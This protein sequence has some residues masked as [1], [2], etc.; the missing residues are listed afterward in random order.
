MK[1]QK[2]R[3]ITTTL[4]Y[5]NADPHMGHGLDFIQADTLAR[6]WRLMGYEV[7]FNTGTDEH[8]QKIAQKADDKGQSRQAYVDHYAAEFQKLKGAFNLSYDKFIRTTDEAHKKA[9]QTIWQ[10][11]AAAGDIYKKKYKGLY[12]VG[13]ELFY[14]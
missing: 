7:F 10:K 11:C 1:E 12:F 4:P 5:V 14:K 6:Y 13:F 3:Y 8:G 9:A 2:A